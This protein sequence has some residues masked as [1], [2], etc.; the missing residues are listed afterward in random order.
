VSVADGAAMINFILTPKGPCLDGRTAPTKEIECSVED[1]HQ[2]RY[3]VNFPYAWYRLTAVLKTAQ[4]PEKQ[5]RLTFIP[6]ASGPHYEAF[7]LTFPPDASDNPHNP[8][9]AVW[10]N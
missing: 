10:T 4:G 5:L 2:G 7:D 9:T 1:L 8:Y 6:G 3:L